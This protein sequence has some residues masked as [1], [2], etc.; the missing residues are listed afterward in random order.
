MSLK[1]NDFDRSALTGFDSPLTFA[2]LRAAGHKGPPDEMGVYA[3]LYPFEER[4]R[5]LTAGSG[6]FFKGKDPNV[7][8]T[9][10]GSRWVGDSRILYFGKAGGPGVSATLR[11]RIRAFSRF[12][13]GKVVGH[14]G[15]RLIWQIGEL[16]FWPHISA[17]TLSQLDV[18][19]L[20][21]D[22]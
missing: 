20:L 13:E 7:A 10:L 17:E 15:G 19:E 4:P 14:Y 22:R 8:V 3:V 6:G 2:D 5:F 11:D 21:P 12:G 16:E 18:P 1:L 9:E